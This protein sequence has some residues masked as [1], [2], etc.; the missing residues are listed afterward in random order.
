MLA[1]D[2]AQIKTSD[3]SS[4]HVGGVND[5][6]VDM[7]IVPNSGRSL[8]REDDCGNLKIFFSKLRSMLSNG[9]K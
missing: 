3:G 8:A 5:E 4:D 2:N 6:P 1:L 9:V 7:H